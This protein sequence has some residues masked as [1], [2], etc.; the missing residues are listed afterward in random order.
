MVVRN[1]AIMFK[2]SVSDMFVSSKPGV[3][4]RVTFLLSRSNEEATS[5]RFVHDIR[6]SP[7]V[8]VELEAKLIN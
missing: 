1:I 2:M 7:T 6:P 8:N 3:S 5:T 4:I